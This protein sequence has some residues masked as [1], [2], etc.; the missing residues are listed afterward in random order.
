MATTGDAPLN[1]TKP[2][3]GDVVSLPV[4]NA[5][6]DAINVKAAAVDV[7]LASHTSSIS[8]LSTAVGSGGAV[9]KATNIA[10]GLNRQ[11]P[12]QSAVNTTTFTGAPTAIGQV[13]TAGLTTV[14]WGYPTPYKMASGTIASGSWTS[15]AA[16]VDLT[17]YGFTAAPVVTLTPLSANLSLITSVTLNSAP[18]ATGFTANARTYNGSAFA[19]AAPTTHWVAIQLTP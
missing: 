7:T 13:L 2:E 5:N 17:S 14:T 6:Y 16:P 12:Y 4:I 3:A 15:G 19:S 18:T 10:G 11:I 1:L 9:V 8:T